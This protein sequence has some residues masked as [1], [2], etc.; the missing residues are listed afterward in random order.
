MFRRIPSSVAVVV[1]LLGLV[2]VVSACGRGDPYSGTWKAVPSA[3]VGALT[4]VIRKANPGWWSILDPAAS[5]RPG[6]VAEIDGELQSGNSQQTFTRS[7]DKLEVTMDPG[8]PPIAF[9]KQ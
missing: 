1:L 6:Y 5:E 4:L 9:T 3:H 8:A 2:G 7:G